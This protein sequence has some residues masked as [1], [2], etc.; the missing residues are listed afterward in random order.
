MCIRDREYTVAA[1]SFLLDGGDGFI[2]PAK[3]ASRNDVGYNDLQA[4]IDYLKTG[5]A[6]VRSAQK[7]VGV[8][9]PAGGLQAGEANEIALTSLSYSSEGEPLAQNVT[10]ALE[11]GA[12]RAE[13]TAVVNNEVSDAD[14]GYG[15]RGRATV[16]V[17][18]PAD[19]AGARELEITTDAG[20]KV[21]LPLTVSSPDPV[22][23]PAPADPSEGSSVDGLTGLLARVLALLGLL[24]ISRLLSLPVG[25]QLSR[26]FDLG[27]GEVH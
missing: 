18:L 22:N 19:A 10:V 21:R 14:K 3:V 16:T 11:G 4:F 23:D 25:Q 5:A 17:D 20:T 26:I 6:A 2:D 15:E 1:S 27:A 7:D 9:L 13:A 12:T 24:D 8:V